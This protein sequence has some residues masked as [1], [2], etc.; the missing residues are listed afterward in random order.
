MAAYGSIR[1]CTITNGMP[2]PAGPGQAK[3]PPFVKGA[4]GDLG[5]APTNF[6]A[7]MYCRRTPMEGRPPVGRP[8]GANATLATNM[9]YVSAIRFNRIS[10]QV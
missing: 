5:P 1:L 4:G 3:A 6:A 8:K 9:A 10:L 7:A 2:V